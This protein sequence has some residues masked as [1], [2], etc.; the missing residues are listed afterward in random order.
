MPRH[1]D[2]DPNMPRHYKKDSNIFGLLMLV[3]SLI[4]GGSVLGYGMGKIDGWYEAMGTCDME[5][6]EMKSQ[7]K[8]PRTP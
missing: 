2:K 4:I 7:M 6:R 1:H 5:K 8:K 3:G